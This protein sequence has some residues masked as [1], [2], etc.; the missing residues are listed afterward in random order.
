VRL[1]KQAGA[2]LLIFGKGTVQQ[3]TTQGLAGLAGAV[4]HLEATTLWVETGK[5]VVTQSTRTNGVGPTS[6]AALDQAYG[7]A[8]EEMAAQVIGEIIEKWS[9]ATLSGRL[10]N[11][12]LEVGDYSK[13]QS[14]R[15][16]LNRVVGVK[17]ATQKGFSG[18]AGTIEITFTGTTE[19]LADLIATTEFPDLRVRIKELTADQLKLAVQ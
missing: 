6:T 11:L 4:V 18:T 1:G 13:L 10:I 2:D 8:G 5:V 16:R 15:K 7:K 19:L 12:Q 9:A 17:K 3:L 14:F